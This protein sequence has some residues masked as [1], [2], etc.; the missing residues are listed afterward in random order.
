[1]LKIILRI[2]FFYLAA[3]HSELCD[4]AK[5]ENRPKKNSKYLDKISYSAKFKQALNFVTKEV[6]PY[7]KSEHRRI[8][9]SLCALLC[10]PVYLYTH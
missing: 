4:K 3:E 10:I 6:A 1:M 7:A 5:L 2:I 8:I 9:F